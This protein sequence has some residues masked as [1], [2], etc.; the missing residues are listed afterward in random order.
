MTWYYKGN[1]VLEIPEDYEAF[2]YEITFLPTNRKY[3]GK[4][5]ATRKV[6]KPPLKGYK[7]KRRSKVESDW[8]EYFGSSDNVKDDLAIHG[9]EAFHR[10]ILM[11]CE[12]PA[13]ASYYEAKFQFERNVLLDDNYYNGIIQCRINRTHIQK[14]L[15]NHVKT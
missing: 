10:E 3:L 1:E 12:T 4:K 6:T 15:K 5:K 9:I 7:R 8:R 14:Y 11:W 13:V 2:V